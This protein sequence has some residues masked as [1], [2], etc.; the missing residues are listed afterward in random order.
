MRK[1]KE[2]KEGR[3][4]EGKKEEREGR[5]KERGR[6]GKI[7]HYGTTPLHYIFFYIVK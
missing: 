4:K 1:E 6:E 3:N 5:R 7:K 2:N